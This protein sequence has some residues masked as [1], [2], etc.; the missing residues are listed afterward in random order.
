MPFIGRKAMHFAYLYCTLL[1][2]DSQEGHR[3]CAV[4][5]VGKQTA[6]APGV[7]RAALQEKGEIEPY[8]WLDCA[9]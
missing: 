2:N 3:L 7:L 6:T 4:S 8:R 1:W 9:D 5:P